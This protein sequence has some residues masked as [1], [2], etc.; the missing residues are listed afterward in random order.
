MPSVKE[1][2]QD[3]LKTARTASNKG[4]ENNPQ[5]KK[6]LKEK[7]PKEMT[8]KARKAPSV[9]WASEAYHYLTDQL[10]TLIEGSQLYRQSFGFVKSAPGSMLTGGKKPADL[11]AEITQALFIMPE[12]PAEPMFEAED[13]GT[14]TTAMGNCIASL[15]K[16][17][18]DQREKLGATGAGLL[19]ANRE[20]EIEASTDLENIWGNTS[21]VVSS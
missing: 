14:L 4:K 21:F 5:P 13:L 1:S 2:L 18:R 3:R 17:Y 16:G 6:P 9:R 11:H 20:G 12:A 15:K 10:L 8:K 7:Q 19:D